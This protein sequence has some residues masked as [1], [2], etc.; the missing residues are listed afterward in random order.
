MID[1]ICITNIESTE[2]AIK[3][4]RFE[5]LRERRNEKKKKLREKGI[6]HHIS[7]DWELVCVLA[8]VCKSIKVTGIF[9]FFNNLLEA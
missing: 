7:F 8:P 4:Y 9:S 1:E 6:H 5:S 2:T 3:V